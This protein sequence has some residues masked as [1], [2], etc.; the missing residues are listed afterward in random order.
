MLRTLLY[1]SEN[2]QPPNQKLKYDR[3][4][5]LFVLPANPKTDL[6]R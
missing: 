4:Q 3:G 6:S 5:N 2:K 1:A